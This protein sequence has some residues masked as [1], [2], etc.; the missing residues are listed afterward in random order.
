MKFETVFRFWTFFA[1]LLARQQQRQRHWCRW[2]LFFCIYYPFEKL[3]VQ[4]DFFVPNLNRFWSLVDTRWAVWCLSSADT[5]WPQNLLLP[6]ILHILESDR[7]STPQKCVSNFF[8]DFIYGV[9]SKRN[10]MKFRENAKIN[11][12][13]R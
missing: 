1:A 12:N 3:Y 2:I 6:M 7:Y 9:H 5:N 4:K 11:W 13:S 10:C 8:S